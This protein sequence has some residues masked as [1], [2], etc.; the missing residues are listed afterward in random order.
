MFI[1]KPHIHHFSCSSLIPP[2]QAF[3][4]G[5]FTLS[6]KCFLF[7]FLFFFPF[8]FGL[9][10][11]PTHRATQVSPGIPSSESV[12]S[13]KLSQLFQHIPSLLWTISC[14]SIHF[15]RI[16]FPWLLLRVFF[17]LLMLCIFTLM[18]LNVAFSLLTLLGIHW[19]S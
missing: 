15:L 1:F 18:Y 16:I 8:F 6:R 13:C 19:T 14:H 17:L 9:E 4:F 3:D 7:F 2:F 10:F 11:P 5:S 12:L